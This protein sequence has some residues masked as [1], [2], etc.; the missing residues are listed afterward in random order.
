M[1]FDRFDPAKGERLE[2]MDKDGRVD[3]SL[4]PGISD[5]EIKD[6][7]IKMSVMRVADKTALSLQREGRM[8]TYAP[9]IGQEGVQA[10]AGFLEARDWLVPSYR[11]TGAMFM[12]G[13]PLSDIFRYWM[14]DERGMRGVKDH[15]CLPIQIVVG[16]QPL[17]AVGLS[18]A[19]KMQGE[20]SVALVLFGDGAT[21]EGSFHEAMNFA[22]VFKT[23]TIFI[24]QNNQ[25]AISV[26]RKSQTASKTIAGKA[27]AYG[28]KGIQVYG[29]DLLA[30]YGAVKEAADEARAGGGP[31]L[32]E[33]LTY[34]FGPH[35]TADD[36]DKYRGQ[37]ELEK[38]RP[39][40]P[41]IRLRLYLNAK[42]LWSEEEEYEI[43]DRAKAEVEK[44]V[45]EAESAPPPVSEDIFRY[46][47]SSIPPYTKRQQ[48]SLTE[49]QNAQG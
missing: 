9:V 38:N 44:A 26:R 5:E 15:R 20:D 10:A 36:P 48:D 21:S 35:T 45:A 7:Y 34:R 16:C 33:A 49:A 42:G 46:T 13:V 41:L 22:G 2:I 11:E 14:G 17:H 23:P 8:G 39:Y 28:F 47:L 4:R 24:C 25:F 1:Y 3:E 32:I 18:W 19:M 43:I 37:E 31:K 29:N 40:D 27:A 6:Y 12:K 30:M